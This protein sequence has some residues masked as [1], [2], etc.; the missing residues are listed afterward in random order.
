MAKN[1][2]E[3]A[4]LS[5]VN[6]DLAL[7]IDEDLQKESE[8][9]QKL[10][11][12]V[13]EA[14]QKVKESHIKR[15][16]ETQDRLKII[17]AAI[18]SLKQ[19]IDQKDQETT[20]EQFNYLLQSK[21]QI[22]D[23]LN[24][25][26]L[27]D[28]RYHIDHPVQ[29][30]LT[31]LKNRIIDIITEEKTHEDQ[32]SDS[33]FIPLKD[34]LMT[35][36]ER[37]FYNNQVM[38]EKVFLSDEAELEKKLSG[39]YNQDDTI[40][41]L[42]E[43]LHSAFKE[44]TESRQHFFYQSVDDD[45]LNDKITALYQKAVE[46][47]EQKIKSI[48]EIFIEKRNQ[49][50]EQMVTIEKDTIKKL[51]AKYEKRLKEE[52]QM[53]ETLQE[54]LKQMKFDIMMA[55]KQKDIKKLQ[56][57]MKKYDD[58]EKKNLSLYE[59]KVKQLAASQTKKDKDNL[60]KQ[61]K[62]LELKHEE[63]LFKQRYQL[64]IEKIK[65][66]ESRSLFKLREDQKSME[67]DKKVNTQ[68]A[69]DLKKFHQ[70]LLN[71]KKDLLKFADAIESLIISQT[72][73]F[74]KNEVEQLELIQPLNNEIKSLQLML[75]KDLRKKAFDEEIFSLKLA[76]AFD[77]MTENVDHQHIVKQLLKRKVTDEKL[78]EV[79]TIRAQEEAK[80]ELIYQH[81]LVEI[82][83][84]EHELQLIKIQSLFESEVDL[85]K[86]QAERLNIGI[87]VNEAMVKTTVE[88][89]I[90]FA[91]QQIK[92]AEKEFEARLENIERSKEQEISYAQQKLNTA[93]QKYLYDRNQLIKER[94]QKLETLAYRMALFTEQKDRK[95][96]KDQEDQINATYNGLIGTIDQN[97]AND[98][99]IIRYSKQIDA[100]QKRA[101]KAIEDAVK[102][103]DKTIDT[104]N[105]LLQ[106]S[107]DKLELFSKKHEETLVPYIESEA[108][109]TAQER[110]DDA[111]KEADAQL[112]EK[113]EK[114][115][116]RIEELNEQLKSL[117]KEDSKEEI[118]IFEA[119]ELAHSNHSE[120]IESLKK[121][122]LESIE[123][124]E[125]KSSDY[126]TQIKNAEN[127]LTQVK[128][129]TLNDER[130]LAKL[131]KAKQL[132]TT[133][134]AD[135]K[136][137]LQKVE[138]ETQ[139]HINHIDSKIKSINKHLDSTIR[140]YKRFLKASSSS[141]NTK[142]KAIHKTLHEQYKTKRTEIE[143]KY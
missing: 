104:F 12:E 135:Y 84:K 100:S 141:Q 117:V 122:L 1:K 70:N 19:D 39:Y 62:A 66:N 44:L 48:D 79:E 96:L 20:I 17:N 24:T 78:T 64:E 127:L 4:T 67:N 65:F 98:P 97:E 113:L 120:T 109:V 91:Q 60:I 125:E 3:I 105:E 71:Y 2:Y 74:M 9:L 138:A 124:I 111:L 83:E 49:I 107:Q 33:Y 23:A 68:L 6:K 137:I 53:R 94:D 37:L 14:N 10:I 25:M 126:L 90:H 80:N 15:V 110:L 99:Q 128:N 21:D 88:S 81:A 85:T 103:R 50:D 132:E 93:K 11:K 143:Q 61:R 34:T 123:I 18:D 95:K 45:I 129:N 32:L 26:R 40:Q 130:L 35:W 112:A 77:V 22:F 133:H 142:Q 116:N 43:Q 52:K 38:L 115:K 29:T 73:T 7:L 59:E 102:L 46:K 55:E 72:I 27:F 86:S 36:V 63:D 87:G 51:K 139:S 31:I 42:F 75:A 82:A 119:M 101:D 69:T 16:Q 57:L 30:H 8:L 114:P 5:K 136:K 76:H 140:A 13:Y 56:T 47:I 54:D 106:Q 131:Q 89:Q 108:N 121:Q 118:R 41:S 28:S 58:L 134:K 92:F